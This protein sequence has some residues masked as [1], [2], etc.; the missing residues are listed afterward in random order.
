MYEIK[1]IEEFS[2]AHNL[3]NYKGKCEE[4][5]G[6][7]WRVEVVLYKSTLNSQGMVLDFKELKD[8]VKRVL[9]GMDHKH[10]NN[11]IYFKRKN[12]TSENIARFI[13]DKLSKVLKCRI[14]IS[15]WETTNACASFYMST[16]RA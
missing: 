4:L 13:H 1:I 7:N 12:P 15:V 2:G 5:H 11:L 10:L 3:R 16:G 6:H 14:K 8:K 9:S